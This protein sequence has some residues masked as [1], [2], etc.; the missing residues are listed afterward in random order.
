MASSMTMPDGESEREQRHVVEGK[1]HAAHE[2]ERGDD[3]GGD[4]DGGDEDSAPVAHEKKND[5]AGENAAED[6]VFEERVDRSFDEVGNVVNDEKLD[7]G[8]KLGAEFIELGFYVVGDLDGVGAG[9]AKDLN[10]DDVLAGSAFAKEGRPGAEFLCAIFDLGYIADT[11]LRAAARADDDFAELFRGSDAAEG[12]KA[13]LLRAGDH[14]AAGG[15]DIFALERVAYIEDGEIVRG[16]FLRVEEDA[17][18]AGL[19]AV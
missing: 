1:I 8:R 9:L 10:A 11:D 12:A 3:A 4:G 14:A 5:G 16:E 7:A 2:G 17:D 18:L 15:F 6:Q 19:A 13:E